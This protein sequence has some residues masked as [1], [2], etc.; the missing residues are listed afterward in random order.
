MANMRKA[1]LKLLG[2]YVEESYKDA[3]AIIAHAVFKTDSAGMV[4]EY[5]Q[6]V[7]DEHVKKNP[8]SEAAKRLKRG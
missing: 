4:R 7:V 2:A 8:N 1:G 5:V 6:A 3:F